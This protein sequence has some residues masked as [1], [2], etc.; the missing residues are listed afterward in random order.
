MTLRSIVTHPILIMGKPTVLGLMASGPK[1]DHNPIY[2]FIN[3]LIITY[4]FIKRIARQ[5]DCS[6]RKEVNKQ[7][8]RPDLQ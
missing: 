3:V 5:K 4:K 2:L 6:I 1:K 8:Q 7:V